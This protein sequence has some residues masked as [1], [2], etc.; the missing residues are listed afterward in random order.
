MGTRDVVEIGKVPAA[1]GGVLDALDGADPY[2]RV[3]V[4]STKLIPSV[5][6]SRVEQV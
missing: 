6:A 1:L 3:L 4:F 2:A 5:I